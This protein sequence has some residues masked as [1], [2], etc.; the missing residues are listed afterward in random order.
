MRSERIGATIGSIGGLAF[1]LI[2][3]GN[4][5]GTASLL[6]RIVGVVAFLA[7]LW[8]AVIRSP[9]QPQPSEPPSRRAIRIYGTSVTAMGIGIPVGANIINNVL[10]LPVLTVPWVVLLVGAH[11]LPFANAFAA[12]VFARLGWTMI[13]LA[14]VGSIVSLVVT[15]AAAPWT[16]VLAG[17]A[18]LAFSSAGAQRARPTA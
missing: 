8:F 15:E 14:V 9:A 3:S 13:G 7:V 17:F 18:L 12:P 10:D 16:G 5:P 6:V 11:F 4:L 2:N 1:I